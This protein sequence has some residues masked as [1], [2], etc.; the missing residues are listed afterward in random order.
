MSSNESNDLGEKVFVIEHMEEDDDVNQ[1]IPPW[2]LLEYQQICRI[3]K[4]VIFSNLSRSAIGVLKSSLPP[5]CTCSIEPAAALLG[6]R[7]VCLLDP[8][9]EQVLSPND[10]ES[11]DAFLF[12]GILGDDPPRDRTAELREIGYPSRHLLEMQM[13]T[14]TAVGVTY[15][16]VA[17]QIPIE[18]IDFMD[19]PTIQFNARESVEMPFRYMVENGQPIMPKGMKQ[20]LYNDMDK[21]FDF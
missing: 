15:A 19:R 14:D 4:N 1:P 12:G 8:K 18:K 6:N 11:F 7:R 3:A 5:S 21:G 17:K 13:T 20:L 2:V 9:A 16:I 10:L